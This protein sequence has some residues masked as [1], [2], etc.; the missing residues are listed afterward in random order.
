MLFLFIGITN[1]NNIQLNLST[2]YLVGTA[3]IDPDRIEQV[4]TNLID[5]AISHT[6][7]NGSVSI[8]VENTSEYIY[9]EIKDSGSGIPEEDLPFIFER[10]YKA[11]KSRTRNNRKKGT[12]LGLAIAKNIIEAHSG[13]ISVKSKVDVG[14][15]FSIKIPQSIR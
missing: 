6:C 1:E 7:E 9:V 2:K 13:T 8:F 3:M 5:N 12:G 4:F 10:F 11:D 14:T 15:T